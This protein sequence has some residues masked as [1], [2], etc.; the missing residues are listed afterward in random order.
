[1]FMFH[2]WLPTIPDTNGQVENRNKEVSKLLKLPSQNETEWDDIL[3]DALWI[4][5]LGTT[6]NEKTGFSSF[7]LLYGRR[8][9]IKRKFE[10]LYG[11]RESIKRK[12]YITNQ[13][14][15][16]KKKKK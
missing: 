6:K 1:M 3:P 11:R 10:L 16:K 14:K 9:S 5:V 7:E 15:K 2:L 12:I 8:E 13:K 4:W